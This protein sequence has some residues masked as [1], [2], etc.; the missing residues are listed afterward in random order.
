MHTPTELLLIFGAF[1]LI[2]VPA[3]MYYMSRPDLHTCGR[4]GK[5]LDVRAQRYWYKVNG[6]NRPF[7]SKCHRNAR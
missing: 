2:V 3:I 5:F 7:C 6:K 1:G 4:C